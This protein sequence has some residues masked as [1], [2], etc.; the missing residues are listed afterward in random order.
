MILFKEAI[1]HVILI[2]VSAEIG[3][4]IFELRDFVLKGG[5]LSVTFAKEGFGLFVRDGDN[6]A[7]R[8]GLA[9]VLEWK[10]GHG[11]EK[12]EVLE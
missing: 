7:A 9:V 5:D 12:G 4:F 1:V 8:S 3:N 6:V 11:G 2:V 10:E